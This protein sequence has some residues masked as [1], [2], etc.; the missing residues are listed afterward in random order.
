MVST[1]KFSEF[2][3]GGDLANGETTVGLAGGINEKYN[4]PWT[5]LPSGT[6]GDRPAIDSSM[7]YRLRL[8]TDS[9]LYEYYNH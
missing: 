5:F 1:V 6:T 4:N 3:S 7:F 8:N 2:S 9:Q